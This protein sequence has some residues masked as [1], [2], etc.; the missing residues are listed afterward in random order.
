M[1][2]LCFDIKFIA[3]KYGFRYIEIECANRKS[4]AFVKKLDFNSIGYDN[5]L[6][7]KLRGKIYLI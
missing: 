4:G 2:C 5:Y 6:T 7:D 3:L 1:Y